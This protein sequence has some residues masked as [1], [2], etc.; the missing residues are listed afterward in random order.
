MKRFPWTIICVI[1]LTC[2]HFAAG[3]DNAYGPW[4]IDI[5]GSLHLE[6]NSNVFY[7][8]SDTD[9]DIVWRVVPHLKF[10]YEQLDNVLFLGELELNSSMY[11]SNKDANITETYLNLEARPVHYGGY[12][13]FGERYELVQSYSPADGLMK[14]GVNNLKI[15]GGYA[16]NHL[17]V[18]G[19]LSFL[20]GTYS[21]GDFSFLNY[22]RTALE[23]EIRYRVNS[24]TWITGL[25]FGN[26]N[27]ADSI[28]NDASF[29]A[30]TG[31]VSKDFTEKTTL[32]FKI[33]YHSEN[34]KGS[35]A[36][37]FNGILFGFTVKRMNTSGKGSLA[38][39][40]E[41][42]IVPSTVAG[43]D[44]G[45]IFTIRVKSQNEF[46]PLFKGSGELMIERDTVGG[47]SDRVFGVK[48]DGSY[49]F[50]KGLSMSFGLSSDSRSSDLGVYSFR[51]FRIYTGITGT[52]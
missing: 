37:D 35:G 39:I 40:A 3:K 43:T 51:Q 23:N 29:W 1:I 52:Y 6:S 9:S 38:L 20:T 15:G 46:T 34:H 16:G 24:L 36:D 41:K 17:D 33:T 49:E 27:Y 22:K 26:L 44:Y 10:E 45:E 21:P 32:E 31:G 19:N 28:F 11:S 30:L 5:E 2:V 12:M 42:Q 7:E 4:N 48:L 13:V 18:S 25:S 8:E 50:R 14:I 47:R